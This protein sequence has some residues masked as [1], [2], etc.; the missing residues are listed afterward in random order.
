MQGPSEDPG[1][2][3]RAILQLFEA[4]QERGNDIEYTIKLSMI[5]IYNDKIRLVHFNNFRRSNNDCRDLLSTSSST[6]SSLTLRRD[7]SG[8][9][10]IPGLECRQVTSPS[11]VTNVLKEGSTSRVSS[12]PHPSLISLSIYS[13]FR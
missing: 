2:N 11:D 9:L 4:S 1:I 12:L 5:E 10:S 8:H 13:L 7:D 3:Q 6:S